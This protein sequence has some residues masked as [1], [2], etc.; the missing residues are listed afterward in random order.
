MSSLPLLLWACVANLASA[1]D[2]VDPFTEPDEAELF[3]AEERVV[4][5]ASRYAQTVAQAPSIVTVVT[6]RE[7]RNRGYRTLSDLL[8]SM[9]GVFVTVS[10]ESRNL[11]WF[12][13]VTSPDNNKFLILIDG[14][15][16]FD[17]VYTHAWIDSYIPLVDVKQV[18]VIKGPGSAVYGTNAFAGVVNIVTYRADDLRGGFA[19]VEAGSFGRRSASGVLADRVSVGGVPVEVRATA[20]AL[21]MDGDGMDVNPEGLRDVSGLNPSRAIYGRFG[22]KVGQLDLS[23]TVVDYRHT[24]FVQPQDDPLSV[25]FQQDNA[26]Y[27]AYRDQLASARYELKL[28]EI[29]HI[30]PQI[31]WQMH[32]DPGQYAWLSDPA[33]TVDPTTGEAT[34]TL[35]GGLVETE[36]RT[37]RFSPSVDIELHPNA[38]HTT[39]LGVGGEF[40][41]IHALVDNAFDDFSPTPVTPSD[42]AVRDP[43]A[44]ISDLYGF[45]QHT[46]T[47]SHFLEL[48]GGA[49]VDKHSF[50]GIF[51]SPRLGVLLVPSDDVVMKVL[52]GRAF[53]AP[54]SRELLV[55]VGTNDL[56][57]NK[58]VAGNPDLKP[59]VI[60]TVESEITAT[61][62]QGLTLRG[63]G[64]FSNIDQEINSTTGND[65]KLGTHFYSNTGNTTV[66]GGEA[67]IAWKRSPLL[68]DTTYSYTHAVD[69]QTN[70]LQYG[71]PM[72]M[73]NSVLGYEPVTGLR[74]S[75]LWDY[76]G[77]RPRADWTPNSKLKDGPPI[78]LLHAGIATDALAGGRM[79]AD[80]SIRNLLNTT[81]QD[82]V[83]RNDA[84]AVEVDDFSGATSP[85]YPNDI[86]AEGRAVTVGVEVKF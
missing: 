73:F 86:T 47:V 25:L 32:D 12:R 79:R 67:Q 69:G 66:Y 5:V 30:R 20:R 74:F 7:I 13:G 41:R 60:D 55:D 31:A 1:A 50:F 23:W 33:T 80:V 26:F 72:H 35:Q 81:Y 56:G 14:V 18:E 71:V 37:S 70:L 76:F 64:F 21:E 51:A 19:R 49:R 22:V 8:R 45:L 40:T 29:G 36:K 53:R 57:E 27:L 77:T 62:V 2:P 4:T 9:P 78:S 48:T 43:N 11:A 39:L 38:A 17:G 24:Y 28:G 63:A 52:Y 34:T 84:D 44:S 10:Q 65:P 6:D 16:F 15:P 42:F 59:E 85:K 54:T 68:I 46:W 75:L 83:Y 58:F 82:L 3:R 61:P